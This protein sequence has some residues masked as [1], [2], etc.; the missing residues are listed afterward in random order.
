MRPPRLAVV[1]ALCCLLAGCNAFS[2]AGTSDHTAPSVGVTPAD[3][4]RLASDPVA[5]GVTGEA[6]TNRSA[7]LAAHR[8]TLAD[9]PVTVTQVRRATAANGTLLYERHVERRYAANRS[10]GGV[11]RRTVGL[12]AD[13]NVTYWQDRGVRLSRYEGDPPRYERRPVG[14]LPAPDVHACD[15]LRA[16]DGVWVPVETRSLGDRDGR[17]RFRVTVSSPDDGPDPTTFVVDEDGFVGEIRRTQRTGL[18]AGERVFEDVTIETVTRYS[19]DD[20]P[21]DRPEWLP[22]ARDATGERPAATSERT[23]TASD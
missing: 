21:L 11:T 15:E 1:L 12:D 14:R 23:P 18:Y 13:P 19:L 9:R 6:V 16:L 10:V 5:P 17:D 22:D 20:G 7:L 8:A 3:V 2:P 4:P